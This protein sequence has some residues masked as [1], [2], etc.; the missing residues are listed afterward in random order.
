VSDFDDLTRVL[1]ATAHPATNGAKVSIPPRIAPETG[2]NEIFEAEGLPFA[3]LDEVLQNVPPEPS[4]VIQGYVAPSAI[5]LV[6]GRPK[7]GKSTLVCAALAAV[8][9]GEQ[10]AGLETQR[11][12]FLLLTEERYDTLAEKARLFDLVSFRQPPSPIG[13]GNET[14][15]HALMRHCAGT[16]PWPQVVEEAVAYCSRHGLAL[17][18]VDTLDRWTGLRGDAENAAGAVNEVLEPLQ[19]AAA[20]GLAVLL[21]S[22]Q[23]KSSG[24]FGE[25]VRGSNALTGGVDVVLELERPSRGLQLSNH[26]RVLRAMSRFSTTPEELFVELEDGGFSAIENPEQ[27]RA[28]GERERVLALLE[29]LGETTTDALGDELDLPKPTVRR[30]LGTLRDHG[31]VARTGEGKKGSPFLWR[32]ALGES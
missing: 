11:A 17:L 12:G 4:W 30:H 26:T 20:S 24:E 13:G 14:A 31:R 6:A 18:A 7:V 19:Y 9:R 3:P 27:M 10:F 29:E 28:D 8:A 16:T 22:H 23:R 25:A 21:V 32:P 15:V 1:D 2:G 5:T